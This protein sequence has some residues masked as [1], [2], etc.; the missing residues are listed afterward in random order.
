MKIET[1]GITADWIDLAA[2]RAKRDRVLEAL[3]SVRPAAER[4]PG[5]VRVACPYPEDALAG[6]LAQNAR[7]WAILRRLGVEEGTELPLDFFFETA[8]PEGDAELAAHLREVAGYDVVLEP[9]G[10]K[11]RTEPMGLS[12]AALDEWVL[13]MLQTGCD[14][15][16]CAFA[17][18][19]AT[20]GCTE[21][22]DAGTPAPERVESMTSVS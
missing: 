16:A 18:W 2:G 19:T 14:H 22:G 1:T 12:P 6:E 11:G 7:T 13:A 17:G 3:R 4:K 5:T 21:K 10:V 15:G 8:G 20:V 9:G